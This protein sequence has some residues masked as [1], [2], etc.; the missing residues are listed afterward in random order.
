MQKLSG[1]QD[2]K[3]SDFRPVKL[4]LVLRPI[5]KLVLQ[6]YSSF[7]VV[8]QEVRKTGVKPAS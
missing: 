1:F 7:T 2:R 3:M 6:F 4:A 5:V 8:L